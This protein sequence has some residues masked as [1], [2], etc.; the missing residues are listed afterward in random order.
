MKTVNDPFAEEMPVRKI[1]IVV[2]ESAILN[3]RGSK[4]DEMDDSCRLM[5]PKRR[6]PK[7]STKSKQKITFTT[8]S[9]YWVS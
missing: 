4:I 9:K 1:Q 7:H 6:Q 3:V 8:T 2:I 5:K